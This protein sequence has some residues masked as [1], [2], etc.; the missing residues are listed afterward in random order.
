MKAFVT[1]ASGF[2]GS[3]LIDHLLREKW[4]ISALGHQ[5]KIT[6]EDSIE[7]IQGD[8]CDSDTYLKTLKGTDVLFHL[9]AALGASLINKEEFYQINVL[10]TA[11]LLEAAEEAGVSKIVHLSSAGVFGSLRKNEVATE[12]YPTNPISNYDKTKLE[13]E[14][15]ALQKAKEGMDIIVI[16]PGWVYGPGDRRTFKLIRVINNKK[17]L[18][19]SKGRRWQT[20]IH[21]MD[22]IEGIFLCSKQGKKG[23]IYHLSGGEVLSVREIVETIATLT[24]RRIPPLRLPLLPVKFTAWILEKLLT[25]LKIEAPLTPGKLS[26]FIHP[27]PLAIDKAK[28]E[29]GFSPQ[30]NFREG[31]ATTFDWYK[32]NNWL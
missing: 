32:K 13:G 25:P 3:H 22:L 27:K 2:I 12:I 16:R 29:I 6:R 26:F 23:E 7:V 21:I 14:K 5:S 24:G 17:F 9:A 8:I 4:S 15:I 30:I 31:M 28:R 18:L 10:G 11:N 1:G 20:P 19:V